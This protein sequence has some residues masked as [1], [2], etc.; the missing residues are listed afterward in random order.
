MFEQLLRSSTRIGDH[1]HEAHNA[2]SDKE[3]IAK[4][5]IAIKEASEAEYWIE[6]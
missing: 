4:M 2:E 1:A 5:Y 3:S 6:L